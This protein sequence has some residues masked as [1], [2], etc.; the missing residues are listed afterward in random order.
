MRQFWVVYNELNPFSHPREFNS[1]GEAF[2]HARH[3]VVRGSGDIYIL[4]PTHRLS[5]P[6]DV[7]AADDSKEAD[8]APIV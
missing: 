7:E 6:V 3:T 8:S 2:D 5:V 4:Q 1:Y